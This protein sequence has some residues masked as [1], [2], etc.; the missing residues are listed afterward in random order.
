MKI[1]L[2]A[3]QDNGK[4][5]YLVALYAVLVQDFSTRR[6]YP[7]RFS[8]HDP[9]LE[10]WLD[11][12][13]GNLVDEDLP[14]KSEEI[15]DDQRFPRGTQDEVTEYALDITE[16]ATGFEQRVSL[17]DFPGEVMRG[18]ASEGQGDIHSEMLGQL[19][20]CD[21]FIVLLDAEALLSRKRWTAKT[22]LSPAKIETIIRKAIAQSSYRRFSKIGVPI[23]FCMSMADKVASL[24]SGAEDARETGYER[25]VELF[26]SFFDS[27]HRHPVL[28]TAVS[29]GE[30]IGIAPP[31][32]PGRGGPFEPFMI[33]K[34]FEFCVAFGALS[35]MTNA[36]QMEDRWDAGAD[37]Y[38]SN[39]RRA[40]DLDLFETIGDWFRSGASIGQTPEARWA[41]KRDTNRSFARSSGAEAAKFSAIVSLFVEHLRDP[42]NASHYSI[43]HGGRLQELTDTIRAGELPLRPVD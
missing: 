20:G 27:A 37:E 3:P 34:P 12:R 43:Y 17:V 38:D 9:R 6:G 21:A 32:A 14:L 2:I 41:E 39:R 29:L 26:P 33:E 31:G 42:G 36:R 13:F 5:S 35:A 24:L 23:A 15:A 18:A 10:R 22:Q 11:D 30:S 7:L 28:V 16:R 40:S 19:T 1:G 8:V 25:I 4:T